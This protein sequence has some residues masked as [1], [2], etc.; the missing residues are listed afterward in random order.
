MPWRAALVALMFALGVVPACAET[1]PSG[2]ELTVRL[3]NEVRPGGKNGDQFLAELAFPVFVNGREM[4]PVG[5]RVEGE[6]RGSGKAVLLSPHRLVL[7]DGTQVDFNA[8]VREIDRGRLRAQE[9]EGTIEEKGSKADAARQAAEIGLAGASVGG[10]AAGSA[11]GMGIGAAAG[12]VAVLVGRKIAGRH[13]TTVIP[14]G[15]QLTLSLARPLDLPDTVAQ[16]SAAER[17]STDPDD[18]RPILRRAGPATP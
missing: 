9:K 3:E 18:R 14:A 11:A 7:P 10:M 5:S 17:R 13:R 4:I 15:T 8:A 1:L 6:V 16:A 12:V 2:T